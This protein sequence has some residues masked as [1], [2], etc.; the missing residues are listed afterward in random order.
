VKPDI[1]NDPLEKD[2]LK[3][4][5]PL[6]CSLDYYNRCLFIPDMNED[7]IILEKNDEKS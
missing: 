6:I 7:M 1:R 3:L 2:P 4:N 5:F